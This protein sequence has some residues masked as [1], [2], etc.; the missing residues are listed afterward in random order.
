MKKARL[1]QELQQDTWVKLAPSGV[2][3]IGVFALRDIPRGCRS[4]FSSG[5]GDWIRISF[6]EAEKLPEHSRNLVETYCLYDETHYFVPEHG[7]K[8]MDIVLY[9]NHS[10]QPNIASVNDGEEFEA[11]RD[12]NAGE[13][14][15]VNYGSIADGLENYI[16]A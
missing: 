13:E 1:L 8:L 15:L 7:F 3:G 16:G 11:L 4:L 12:I 9:L 5:T 10:D 14:L 6:E 2:H